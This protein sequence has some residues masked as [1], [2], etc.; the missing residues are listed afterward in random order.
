MK[1]RG[2]H[3]SDWT[4]APDC[5]CS[6]LG[7]FSY[8]SLSPKVGRRPLEEAAHSSPSSPTESLI[9]RTSERKQGEPGNKKCHYFSVKQES[10]ASVSPGCS[11]PTSASARRDSTCVLLTLLDCVLNDSSSFCLKLASKW[12]KEV[13]PK[14]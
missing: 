4:G 12:K 11:R 10:E 13:R 1:P 9:L 6:L 5:V 3:G 14:I 7:L 2:I 8:R